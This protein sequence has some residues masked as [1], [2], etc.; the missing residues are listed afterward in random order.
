[1]Q[2]RFDSIHRHYDLFNHLFSMG[3]DVGWRKAA[4]KEAMLDKKTFRVLDVATGTGDL[5][6]AISRLA[7]LEGKRALITGMDFNK[8]MLEHARHKTKAMDISGIKLEV[9][10]ALHIK[11][12]KS[13][14]DVVA[15]G[16]AMR[17]FDSLDRFA[18]E[19]YRV[20]KKGGKLVM[21]DMGRPDKPMPMMGAYFRGINAVGGI[22]GKPAYKWLTYSIMKFDKHKVAAIFA[23][24]GFKNVKVRELR[25]GIAF[26]I[27]ANK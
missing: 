3:V 21:L 9:G 24:H 11:H 22:T 25:T 18:D 6:I 15:S 23:K 4:A 8:P 19:A 16:F 20:M 2:E 7:S 26:I 12:P 17:S 27:T 14:F 13:T 10:D 1:V 5:A